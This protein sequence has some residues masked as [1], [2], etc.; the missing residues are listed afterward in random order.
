MAGNLPL[1]RIRVLDLTRVLAGPFASQMLGDLGAEVIKVERPGKGDECRQYGPPFLKDAQGRPTPESSF[2][3]SVNR[4]K[5]SI[6]LDISKP[7]GQDIVRKLA[8]HCDVL[9]ENFKVGDLERYGLDYARLKLVNPRLVYCSVTGF[10]QTGPYRHRAGYDSIFQGMSGLMSVTG[11]PP[12]MPGG[13]PM[14]TGPSLGDIMSGQ[15][16][17]SAIMAALYQR[18]ANGGDA[19]LHVDVALLDSLIAANS[20]YS[21]H[22]LVSGDVP[23]RR[24][25]EGKGGMPSRLF[26]CADGDIMLVAGNDAQYGRLCETLG[27]PELASDPRFASNVARVTNRRALGQVFEPL[28]AQWDC[29]PLLA[30]L[31]RAGVP[32]GPVYDLR[33]VFDDPQV[34]ARDMCVEI[35]HPA[36][37]DGKVKLVGH[38][39]KYSETPVTRY[40]APPR[41]GEHTSEVLRTVLGFSDADI[42]ALREQKIL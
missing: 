27:R 30:A 25:T 11:N 1:S 20:H 14:K 16:A 22:F 18:D 19:G 32:A 36:A 8:G 39:V 33:Q 26:H 5:K 38:P 42:A 12:D 13:G 21:S 2:Y 35:A 4:N 6:A 34:R 23:V 7:Q 28:F 10:G 3:L 29:A 24:G 15:F 40:T 41:L 37:G 17:V 31:E 9:I